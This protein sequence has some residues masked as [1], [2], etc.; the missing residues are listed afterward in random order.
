MDE[1]EDKIKFLKDNLKKFKSVKLKFESLKW[2]LIQALLAS[3]DRKMS[4]IIFLVSKCKKEN[5][6]TW[7]KALVE[8][9]FN[10]RDA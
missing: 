10:V 5:F 7:R 3:G 8:E 2:S 6:Q 4:R 9:D 1:M